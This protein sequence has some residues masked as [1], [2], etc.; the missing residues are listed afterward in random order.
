MSLGARLNILITVLFVLIFFGASAIVIHNAKAAVKQETESSA[1]YTIQLIEALFK[2]TEVSNRPELQK[3]LLDNLARHGSSRHLQISIRPI[4][5]DSRQK[6]T[7]A[8]INSSAPD[9]FAGLVNTESDNFEKRVVFPGRPDVEIVVY[10][11]PAAEITEAWYETRS[12]L[13]FLILFITLANILLY[14]TLRRYLKPVESILTGLERIEHGDYHSRLPA[15][16]LPELTRISD[17][18]NHMADVLLASRQE[19]LRLA[20]KNL[21]IQEDERRHLA[22]ELHDEL[23]QSLSAIKAVAVS[24]EQKSAEGD[25]SIVENARAIGEFSE[26]MYEVARN[27]MQRL[28]PGVLDELGLKIAIQTLADEWNQS[29]ADSFCHLQIKGDISDLGE[30]LNIN[31]YRIVQESL[32]NVVKHAKASEVFVNIERLQASIRLGIR[33]NGIGVELPIQKRGLGMQGIQERVETL[34]GALEFSS[35]IDKGLSID[36]SFPLRYGTEAE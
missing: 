8:E 1:R 13:F 6:N 35:G 25:S 19:N 14:F 20:Q 24:I 11:D 12:M 30:D 18:F 21:L 32:T 27:M 26:R 33:D 2:S 3:R 29:Y 34:G 36:I 15:Y 9:W 23:G 16:E 22:Q 17:K 10:A 4:S 28:R 5:E 7:K 31:L